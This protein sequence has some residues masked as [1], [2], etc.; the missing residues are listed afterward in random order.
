MSKRMANTSICK[1]MQDRFVGSRSHSRNRCISVPTLTL[2]AE[3]APHGQTI[4]REMLQL[5][6]ILLLA[7]PIPEPRWGLGL[8]A[9]IC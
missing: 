5:T 7:V 8:G 1:L 2:N 9:Q 6:A 3:T 4:S